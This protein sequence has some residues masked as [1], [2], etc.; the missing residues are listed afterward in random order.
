MY[1]EYY[2]SNDKSKTADFIINEEQIKNIVKKI[3]DIDPYANTYHWEKFRTIDALKEFNFPL[4]IKFPEF[5]NL[6]N[7]VNME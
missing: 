7:I 2:M 6:M 3:S 1:L 5:I 4:N